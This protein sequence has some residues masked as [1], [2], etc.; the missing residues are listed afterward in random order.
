[1][2]KLVL[3]I[4]A[5]YFFSFNLFSQDKLYFTDVSTGVIYESLANG[6]DLNALLKESNPEDVVF[7]PTSSYTY[8][9]DN[10]NGNI[11]RIDADG[12]VSVL[13]SNL[14]TPTGLSIDQSGQKLY[15]TEREA[16]L[17]SSID[18]NTLAKEEILSGLSNP[19]YIFYEKNEDKIYWTNFIDKA[20]Y[21]ANSDGT[22]MSTVTSE[23]DRALNLYIDIDGGYIYWIQS[24]GANIC[25]GIW[26]QKSDGSGAKE[27][28]T[29][30]SARGIGFDKANQK[31]YWMEPVFNKMH[32][33]NLDGTEVEDLNSISFGI[34]IFFDSENQNIYYVDYNYG[35]KIFKIENASGARSEVLFSTPVYNPAGLAIDKEAEKMYWTNS[36]SSF[37]DDES[38]SLM[39]ANLD[40]SNVQL[41]TNSDDFLD[42]PNGIALNA[43]AGQLY[44][45]DSGRDAIY[46][47]DLNDGMVENIV[48]RT[49]TDGP[50]DICLDI[51]GG[52]IYWTDIFGK[53]I[54]KADLD[55][56]NI[57]DLITGL[58]LPNY[59][60]IDPKNEKIYWSD[61]T[62]GMLFSSSTSGGTID[63]IYDPMASFNGASG[64]AIDTASGNIYWANEGKGFVNRYDP[65]DETI[66]QLVDI[67]D[68]WNKIGEVVF[69]YD[70]NRV[71]TDQIELDKVNIFP[72]PTTDRIILEGIL[73]SAK[74]EIYDIN[75]TVL[76]RQNS[77][78]SGA[79]IDLS[80]LN[81]GI[82]F[83]R[84]LKDNGSFISKKLVIQ[85]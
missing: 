34:S 53:R 4:T 46:R 1:M 25:N 58:S 77:A 23:P 28:V 66:T 71:S 27:Q 72:N 9:T 38:F 3:F 41:L 35:D 55:G 68:Q 57:E 60:D 44:W 45:V 75:G 5:I 78:N 70:P 43:A 10:S 26:R 65:N 84:I 15:V 21:K 63:T 6:N 22:G 14:N 47:Y 37:S 29:D 69:I 42:R 56:E 24:C 32:R 7:D 62:S 52:K 20:I 13:I 76:L 82:H 64:I 16:G 54:Q 31:I 33:S 19:Y 73:F 85:K 17:I 2:K 18:L 80:G 30:N 39:S 50:K 59:I 83:V 74:I 67:T 12:L 61:L 36:T 81:N 79:E 8:F 49:E 51:E 40:G 11:S 48:W